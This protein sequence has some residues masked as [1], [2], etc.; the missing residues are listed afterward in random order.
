MLLVSV[1]PGNQDFAAG[2]GVI[3][4][5]RCCKPA[6]RSCDWVFQQ[7]QHDRSPESIIVRDVVNKGSRMTGF[8]VTGTRPNSNRT[9][10]KPVLLFFAAILANDCLAQDLDLARL[11]FEPATPDAAYPLA[12]PLDENT[13]SSTDP[14]DASREIANLDAID[15]YRNGINASIENG[16]SYSGL[17]REQYFSL[18]LAQQQ[19]GEHEQAIQSFEQAMQIDRVNEGLFTLS[20]QDL[21]EAI[22]ESHASLG[23]YRE[24]ADYREYLY[25]VQTRSYGKDDPRLLA[26]KEDWADWN[27]RSYLADKARSPRGMTIATSAGVDNDTDYV[28]IY[29]PRLGSTLY[30]PRNQLPNI[31]GP[32][33]GAGGGDIYQRSL[34]YSVSPEAIVDPR[35][36]RAE[37][38]YEEIL[39]PER[40]GVRSD[41]ED[42]IREKL[43]SVAYAKKRQMDAIEENSDSAFPGTASLAL[44]RSSNPVVSRGFIDIRDQLED[45]IVKLEAAPDTEPAELA[46]AWIKLGDWHLAY[47]R[48]QR[49]FDAYEKAWNL[50]QAASLNAQELHDFLN[51]G[52][53]LPI[54]SFTIV[55]YSRESA[56]IPVDETLDYKGFIDMTLNVDRYGNVRRRRV[57]TVSAGTP[58]E[59]RRK[60]LDFLEEQ[61]M[62]PLIVDGS[63]ASQE[64]LSIRYY[65]TY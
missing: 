64:D 5:A 2:F 54:P 47:D 44:R 14:E 59:V 11:V 28:A 35:I 22:I 13:A 33:A 23:N 60:L 16:E 18:G 61:P 25:L 3:S 31:L 19:A 49:G 4:C 38:L 21:V 37:A 6:R 8:P 1:M 45:V 26:A 36:K 17:I 51:P 43:G 48:S 52:P 12:S 57:D 46:A 55:P 40:E 34:T 29:N 56:G 53:L 65:Y 32:L 62:R 39:D 58:P 15:R 42:R 24:V 63:P 41:S 20:Q 10:G 7:P 30:V 50:L 9:G 27:I